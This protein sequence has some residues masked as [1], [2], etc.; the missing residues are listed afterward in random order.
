MKE[1]LIK[2]EKNLQVNYYNDS[3]IL[4]DIIRL[5]IEGIDSNIDSFIYEL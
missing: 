2:F 4:E 3:E 1:N 5:E